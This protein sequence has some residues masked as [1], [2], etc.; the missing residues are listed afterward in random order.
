MRLCV[1]VRVQVCGSSFAVGPAGALGKRVMHCWV[2]VRAVVWL[3]SFQTPCSTVCCTR[4]RA[5]CSGAALH[6]P[7]LSYGSHLQVYPPLASVLKGVSRCVTTL[8]VLCVPLLPQSPR[9]TFRCL[10]CLDLLL[11]GV[12]HAPCAALFHRDRE[13]PA[14]LRC[15][16]R[17]VCCGDGQGGGQCGQVQ[18]GALTGVDQCSRP[19]LT[20][21]TSVDQLRQRAMWSCSGR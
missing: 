7:P 21:L 11:N 4:V 15:D 5:M 10:T 18:K 17:G 14:D 19:A 2:R 13:P 6:T 1:C 16:G 9:T 20:S 8:C 12:L 3:C